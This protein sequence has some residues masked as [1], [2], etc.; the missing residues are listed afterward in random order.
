MDLEAWIEGKP[1]S[2]KDTDS[3]CLTKA[4]KNN[5]DWDNTIS[6]TAYNFKSLKLRGLVNQLLEEITPLIK[7]SS[8]HRQKEALKTILINLFQ[9]HILDKMVRYSRDSNWYN[10]DRRYGKLYFKYSRLIPLIDALE[11]LGYIDQKAGFYYNED[12]QGKQTRMWATDKLISLFST[13]HLT[14]SSF[15]PEKDNGDETIF[16][17]NKKKQNIGYPETKQTRKMREYLECYNAFVQKHR[18][19]LLLNGETIVDNRFFIDEI[20]RYINPTTIFM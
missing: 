6:L 4:I 16:L 17:R 5:N 14:N 8:K 1:T 13:Y 2:E 11:T 9:A 3:M 19:S 12:G 7:V 18:I 20:Y 10:H 15:I